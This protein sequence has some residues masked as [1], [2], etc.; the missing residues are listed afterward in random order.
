[1]AA[2]L[3]VVASRVGALAELLD[4]QGLV[5]AGDS[6]ALAEAIERLAGDRVAGA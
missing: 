1:M 6:G 4:A 3:P 2:G 5:P